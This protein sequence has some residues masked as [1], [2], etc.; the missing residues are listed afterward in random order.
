[1]RP[2]Q[3][4][5]FGREVVEVADGE[6]RWR[7]CRWHRGIGGVREVHHAAHEVVVDLGLECGL[8]LRHGSFERDLV[9]AVCN[10]GHG[11]SLRLQPGSGA[12]DVVAGH[13]E[14]IGKLCRRKPLVI[15]GRRTILLLGEQV[16]EILLLRLGG[17]KYQRDLVEHFAGVGAAEIEARLGE[18]VN[19]ALDR[20]H[21]AGSD[22]AG[23]AVG[24]RREAD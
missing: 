8:D 6:H 22:F 4:S 24:D 5:G 17:M 15:V 19:I 16:I 12:L 13:T 23:N 2:R 9:A 20:D 14:A 10:R 3:H 1:M 21:L 7:Q 18:A 11:E